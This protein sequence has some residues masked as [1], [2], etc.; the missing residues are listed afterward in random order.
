MDT[1]KD[2]FALARIW[3]ARC[4]DSHEGC[5]TNKSHRLP[6]RLISVRPGA[7]K[8][9][10]TITWQTTP[11]Y[12]TLSY[13]WGKEPFPT[14]TRD[15]FDSFLKHI[16]EEDLPQTFKDAIQAT[17][18]LGLEYIWIDALCIIQKEADNRDW[19]EEAGHMRSVYGGSFVNLAASEAPSVYE[20]FL[21]PPKYCGGFAARVT[22]SNYSAV[23]SFNINRIYSLATDYAHLATRAW[24]LQE[25]LLP[26]RTIH[27]GD[28]GLFWE[29]R[30]HVASESIP[31][32]ISVESA[33]LLLCPED[34]PWP[35]EEIVRIYSQANLTYNSDRLP[36]LAGIAQ[37]QHEVTGDLYLA[38]LWRNSLIQ[39]LLWGC[40]S[41]STKPRPEWRAPTWSWASVDGQ[42]V[43]PDTEYRGTP[44]MDKFVRIENKWKTPSGHDAYSAA[45]NR[46]LTLLCR[47]LVRGRLCNSSSLRFEGTSGLDN[48]LVSLDCLEGVSA[49]D[50]IYLLPFQVVGYEVPLF[51][52][53][54]VKHGVVFE[55]LAL[56][57]CDNSTG[58]CRRIGVFRRY[59]ELWDEKDLIDVL[60]EETRVAATENDD[61]MAQ[62]VTG[63]DT[64][65]Y[66]IVIE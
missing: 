64:W 66:R 16:P 53:G 28:M 51:R 21:Y 22:T 11:R 2:P 8:L 35:W 15:N 20:G 17:W 26:I 7:V 9:V 40:L 1:P 36:A 5:R 55:G 59:G 25:R 57:A 60:E 38:G 13:C 27:F 49:H 18:R 56:R 63:D 10:T 19:K 39:Q 43:F 31:D 44:Y 62:S 6:S 3:L 30:S 46:E 47:Y 24:T 12:A 45:F 34:R 14:L 37:R 41:W 65:R 54:R 58:H 32:G 61:V 23:R 33:R 48:V 42:I 52:D 29:C 4:T 50:V